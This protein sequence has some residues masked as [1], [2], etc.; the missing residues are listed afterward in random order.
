LSFDSFFLY[1]LRATAIVNK[2]NNGTFLLSA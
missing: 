2:N 1:S